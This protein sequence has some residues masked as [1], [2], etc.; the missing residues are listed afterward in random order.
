MQDER[1]YCAGY[2]HFETR[3]EHYSAISQARSTCR[4][5]EA[6]F[7]AGDKHV[8]NMHSNFSPPHTHTQHSHTANY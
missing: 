1:V 3:D 7:S 2:K 8:E 6:N 5:C 4:T